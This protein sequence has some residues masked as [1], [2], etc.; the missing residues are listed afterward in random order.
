MIE[1]AATAD[2]RW[3]KEGARLH[4]SLAGQ[5]K[6]SRN[7]TGFRRASSE[8]WDRLEGLRRA[9]SDGIPLHFGPRLPDPVI[10]FRPVPGLRGRYPWRAPGVVVSSGR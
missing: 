8:A 1:A 4:S 9:M 10:R 3:A 6:S 2:H 7:E 5:D